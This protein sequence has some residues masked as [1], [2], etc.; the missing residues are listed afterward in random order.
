MNELMN[1]P[2][3][4]DGLGEFRSFV[5]IHV[6]SDPDTGKSTIIEKLLNEK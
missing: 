5:V 2:T 1:N 3:A 6:I 4:V